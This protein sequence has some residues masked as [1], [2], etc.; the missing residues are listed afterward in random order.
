MTQIAEWINR[1]I[2]SKGDEVTIA[3]VRAEVGDL[4]ARFPL[5]H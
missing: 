5:Q 1:V 3:T 4:C 2:E